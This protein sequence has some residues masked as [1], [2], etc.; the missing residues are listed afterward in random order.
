MRLL[1]LNPTA[2]MGGAERVLL[3]LLA[4]V[5]RAQPSWPLALIVGQEGPLAEDAATLG[6]DTQVLPFPRDFAQ[7]GDFGLATPASA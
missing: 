3:D 2:A 1:Y 7:L 4:I 6:V 5:R